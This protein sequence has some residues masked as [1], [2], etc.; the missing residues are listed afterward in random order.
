L[1]VGSYV[2]FVDLVS[3]ILTT[4]IHDRFFSFHM[5]VTTGRQTHERQSLTA[6]HLLGGLSIFRHKIGVGEREKE[7]AGGEEDGV[8]GEGG[9]ISNVATQ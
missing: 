2:A 7:E 5:Q 1:D 6:M 9:G 4:R 8:R 3:Y